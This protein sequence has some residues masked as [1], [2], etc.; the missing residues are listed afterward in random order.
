MSARVSF[1]DSDENL[2]AGQ[3]DRLAGMGA[4]GRNLSPQSPVIV[5]LRDRSYRDKHYKL[6]AP[7]C[8]PRTVLEHSASLR[9]W[10]AIAPLFVK[11]LLNT[12]RQP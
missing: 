11:K 1:P 4:V 3:I 7:G 10:R 5:V 12:W 9:C 2:C 6:L 8:T